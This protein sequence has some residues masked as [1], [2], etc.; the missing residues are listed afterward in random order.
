MATAKRTASSE[1]RRELQRRA[2]EVSAILQSA[3]FLDAL[4]ATAR[5]RTARAAA[6]ADPKKWIRQQKLSLPSG[7][8]V[9]MEERPSASA[10]IVGFCVT[11]CITR[12]GYTCCATSCR[13][14]AE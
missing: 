1:D 6:V 7:A 11:V 2:K 10:R 9:T 14:W 13:F 12:N 8:K 5:D 3:Q 4:D